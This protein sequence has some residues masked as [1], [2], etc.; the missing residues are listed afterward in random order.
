MTPK[1]YNAERNA[2]TRAIKKLVTPLLYP[3]GFRIGPIGQ[4]RPLKLW[5]PK[6]KNG[7]VTNKRFKLPG[8]FVTHEF[9]G[10]TEEGVIA[11]SYGHGLVTTH[12]K[13]VP[14]EDLFRMHKWLTRMLPRLTANAMPRAS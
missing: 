7:K 4:S 2:L 13:E 12:W 3:S 5:V 6:D 8:A 9:E 11:D 10:F 1:E 14:I